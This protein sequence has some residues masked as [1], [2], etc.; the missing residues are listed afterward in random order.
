MTLNG[1]ISDFDPAGLFGLIITDDG[2]LLPF[3]LRETPPA[4][5]SRFEISS[6]PW[7]S[8]GLSEQR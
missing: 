2:H 7:K 6:A 1:T 3:N 8:G 4:L 5:R